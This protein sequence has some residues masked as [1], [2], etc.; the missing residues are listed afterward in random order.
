M[1]NLGLPAEALKVTDF[2]EIAAYGFMSTSALAIDDE[3]VLVGKV[4]TAGEIAA[5]L[6]AR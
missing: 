3:V 2:A 4:L 6:Q 1:S 5:F